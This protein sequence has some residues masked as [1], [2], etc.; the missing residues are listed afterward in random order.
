MM[1]D[2]YGDVIYGSNSNIPSGVL[3]ETC[4]S[5]TLLER[6][7][8]GGV[9]FGLVGWGAET[10]DGGE[11]GVGCNCRGDDGYG[12]NGYSKIVIETI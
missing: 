3:S 7:I 8:L 12:I 11:M 2:D 9:K 10:F 1:G 6:D 4:P 5:E